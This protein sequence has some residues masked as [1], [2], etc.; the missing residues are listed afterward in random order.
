M[1]FKELPQEDKDHLKEQGIRSMAHFVEVAK[2]QKNMR[3]YVTSAFPD[4]KPSEP[5]WQCRSIAQKLGLPV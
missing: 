1:K 2:A 3:E 4:H 5:C